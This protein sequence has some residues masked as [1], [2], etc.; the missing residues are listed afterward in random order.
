[1]AIVWADGFEVHGTSTYVARKYAIATNAP[2]ALT[3][4]RLTGSFGDFNGTIL[5][6]PSFGVENEWCVGIGIQAAGV[7]SPTPFSI[8]LFT[9]ATEQLRLEMVTSG[10]GFAWALKRGATVLATTGT[11]HAFNVWHYFELKVTVRTGANGS[12][13][14]R[15]NE[16]TL[17]SAAGVNT[18]NAGSDG[19]DVLG[20]GYS[21]SGSALRIDDLYIDQGVGADFHGDSYLKGLLPNADGDNLDWTPST[22][23]DHYVLVDDPASASNDADYVSSAIMGDVD[24][25]QYQDLSVNNDQVIAVLV[26][27]AAR[28]AA[29]GSR[30]I[31]AVYEEPGNSLF[32]GDTVVVASTS[33]AEFLQVWEDNPDTG[34]PWEITEI[35]DGRFG[36]ESVN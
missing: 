21:T 28:M 29:A 31:R 33:V 23:T 3:P 9:G 12:Y 27:T 13:E 32:P 6:T 1:M 8:R 19:A 11:A 25:Y 14:I 36:I 4:G 18:A 2:G 17:T 20:Y 5:V 26:W 30:Q 7:I 22:G 16:I 15:H 10:S 24:T 34:L 35:N